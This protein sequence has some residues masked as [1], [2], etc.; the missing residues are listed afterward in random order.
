M[1]RYNTDLRQRSA[2]VLTSIFIQFLTIGTRA[3]YKRIKRFVSL[4]FVIRKRNAFSCEEIFVAF[5]ERRYKFLRWW[6]ITDTPKKYLHWPCKLREKTHE[7]NGYFFIE[8]LYFWK[9]V[10]RKMTHLNVPMSCTELHSS[11]LIQTCSICFMFSIYTV[12]QFLICIE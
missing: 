8:S 12:C 6:G 5:L 1:K 10:K 11:M 9:E 7:L 3:F 4:L 2:S